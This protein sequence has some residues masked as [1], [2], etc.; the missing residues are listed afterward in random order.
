MKIIYINNE[1]NKFVMNSMDQISNFLHS[2]LKKMG[3]KDRSVIIPEKYW[4]EMKKSPEQGEKIVTQPNDFFQVQSRD[5][6]YVSKLFG[7]LEGSTKI[8]MIIEKQ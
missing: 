8:R 7:I 2:C 4:M 5:L 6:K 3:Y 1:Y